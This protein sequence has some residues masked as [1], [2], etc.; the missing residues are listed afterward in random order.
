MTGPPIRVLVA[1]DHLVVRLGLLTLIRNQPD[2][3]VVAEAVNG[4]EVIDLYRKHQPDIIL[5]DL[6]MPGLAGHQVIATLCAESPKARVIVLTIHKADEIVYQA[7]HAGASGYL[8]KDVPTKEIVAAIRTVHAGQSLP[9]TLSPQ[10]AQRLER[11]ALSKRE[12]DVL[13]LTA[14]GLSN[15]EVGLQLGMTEAT[16]K[17]HMASILIKLRAKDRAHAVRLGIER[18]YINVET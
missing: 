8:F 12:I 7:L 4:Q 11:A 14:E 5:M 6:R 13:K 16:A 1:D 3:V 17:K 18:G 9:S 2:M 10:V 15:R